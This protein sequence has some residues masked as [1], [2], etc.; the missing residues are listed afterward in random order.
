MQ[1]MP[2][3]SCVDIRQPC[4]CICLVSTQCNQQCDREDW[5][6]EFHI[7]D[8]CQI[9]VPHCTCM[10]H[11]TSITV[12]IQTPHYCTSKSKQ[13]QTTNYHAIAIYVQITNMSLICHITQTQ[14]Q[15]CFIQTGSFKQG[16]KSHWEGPPGM[17]ILSLGT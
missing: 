11:C 14:G 16:I 10:V 4:Q 1:H 3:T 6:H 15:N 9:C 8:I 12:Y 2:V 17:P 5:I 7:M 13:Q